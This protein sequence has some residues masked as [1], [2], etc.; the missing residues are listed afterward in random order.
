MAII[1]ACCYCCLF[2]HQ[3]Q[4]IVNVVNVIN[5]YVGLV[6]ELIIDFCVL[7]RVCLDIRAVLEMLFI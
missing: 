7:R 4:F 2:L 6:D 5:I 3:R 1:N